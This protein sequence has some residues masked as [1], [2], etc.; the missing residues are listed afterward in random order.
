M[1]AELSLRVPSWKARKTFHDRVDCVQGL[2][3]DMHDKILKELLL[4]S[5]LGMWHSS[6]F[7]INS[8]RTWVGLF[9]YLTKAYDVLN[10]QILL[11]KLADS[12]ALPG[13][14]F[15]PLSTISHSWFPQI[16]VMYPLPGNGQA[17]TY[18]FPQIFRPLLRTYLIH[19]PVPLYP[20]YLFS[21]TSIRQEKE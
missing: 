1:Q 10:N 7:L 16:W 17:G 2:V 19:A 5:C 18:I 12:P 21:Q 9:L 8:Q 11:D 14:L 13:Y 3:L 6:Q 15:I 20:G 4:F